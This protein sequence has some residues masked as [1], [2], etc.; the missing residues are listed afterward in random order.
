VPFYQRIAHLFSDAA[1]TVC[2]CLPW[3]V[4]GE[5]VT[6]YKIINNEE[7]SRGGGMNP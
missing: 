3:Q 6:L 7:V 5:D 1:H 2:C 4:F